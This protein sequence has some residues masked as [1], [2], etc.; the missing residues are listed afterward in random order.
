M[1][2]VGHLSQSL[3]TRYGRR[4]PLNR[5]RGFRDRPREHP[6]PAYVAVGFPKERGKYR[7]AAG[8]E[9]QTARPAT[10]TN[11]QCQAGSGWVGRWRAG[12]CAHMT[13]PLTTNNKV[14]QLKLSLLVCY[15]RRDRWQPGN[16]YKA[17]PI[18]IMGGG[19]QAHG[20]AEA[21]VEIHAPFF[22]EG[23]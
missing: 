1:K 15:C 19:R 22:L 8:A 5:R 11:T 14:V 18:Y 21:Y 7:C 3:S 23:G 13:W 16:T 17:L 2:R 10:P 6:C 4:A 9:V 20:R 12:T